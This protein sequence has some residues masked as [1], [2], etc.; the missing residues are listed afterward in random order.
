MEWRASHIL[1]KDRAQAEQLKIRAKQGADF[2]S[3][4]REFS[5][6]PSKSAGGDLGWFG[7]GKMVPSFEHAC[8]NL[9]VGSISDVVSTQFGYHIIKLTGKKD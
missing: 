5:T 3:L 8:K 2:G 4:A 1:V 7:P 9:G 6:C